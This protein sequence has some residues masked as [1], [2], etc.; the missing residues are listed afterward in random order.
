[1][2]I[3]F[4]LDALSAAGDRAWRLQNDGKW[5]PATF[6]EDARSGDRLDPGVEQIR[7]LVGRRLRRDRERGLLAQ[8]RPGMF[9]FLMRG[10]FAHAVVHRFSSPAIPERA[11]MIATLAALPP[12]TPWLLYLDL[13]G[14]FRAL[15]TGVERIIGNLKIA[16]R[17]EIAS[18]AGY[19]G[20]QAAVDT[21]YVELLYRQFLSG[22]LEHLKSRKPGV[23]V[24]D[25]EKLKEVADLHRMIE[26]ITPERL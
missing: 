17:G 7:D 13:G 3:G 26:A 25:P 1:M 11:Q 22:W 5:R 15:D 9:D 6:A 14:S 10:I 18:A 21:A 8:E 20:A 16:V 24:P 23:F 19:V 4:T 2:Q 12:G